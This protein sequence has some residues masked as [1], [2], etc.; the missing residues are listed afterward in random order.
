MAEAKK[1]GVV[2]R[3]TTQ[4]L[5][6]GV[7]LSLYTVGAITVTG[8]MLAATTTTADAQWRGRGRGRGRGWRGRGRG[9]RGRGLR[10]RGRLVCGH[11]AYSSRRICWRV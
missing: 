1:V 4:V 7:L 3:L 8:G 5:A 9:W 10:G 6:A 2:R 11:R